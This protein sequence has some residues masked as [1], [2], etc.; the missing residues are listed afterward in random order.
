VIESFEKYSPVIAKSAY[1]HDTSVIIGRVK[2]GENVSVWPLACV[3]ADVDRIEIGD[4]SNIQDLVA[5]H[6]NWDTPTIIGE[7]VTVGHSAVIHGAKIGNGCLVGMKA[8]VMESEI[9]DECII[10]GASVVPAGKKIPPR[11][12][13]MGVPGKIVKALSDEEIKAVKRNTDFYVKL[14]KQFKRGKNG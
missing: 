4:N 6:V 13:V 1:I 2:L 10:A 5:V 8:L 11:S 14:A 3:R 7:S 12:L 9:G